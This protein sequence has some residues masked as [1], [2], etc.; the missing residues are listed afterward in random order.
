M[1]KNVREALQTSSGHLVLQLSL[2][3]GPNVQMS[4][5]S[6][7]TGNLKVAVTR[8][9]LSHSTFSFPFQFLY[10]NQSFAPAPDVDVGTLYECFGSDG[11]LVLH[12]CRSQAWG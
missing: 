11:K 10:V 7:R 1:V 3:A 12:Y 9:I 8:I 2:T 5:R 4:G 6:D